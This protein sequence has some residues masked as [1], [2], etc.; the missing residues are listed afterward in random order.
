VDG[1][2]SPWEAAGIVP[3]MIC[4][5]IVAWGRTAP[6]DLMQSMRAGTAVGAFA[7]DG[8]HVYVYLLVA[9]DSPHFD[10]PTGERMWMYDSIELWLE[11]EQIGLGFRQDGRPVL[12]KY[13]FHDRDGKQYAAG[14]AL[15]DGNIWGRVLPSLADHPLSRTLAAATGKSFEGRAGYALMAKIPFEDI[16][17]VGGIAGRAGDKILPMTGQTGEIVRIGVAIDCISYAG[18]EQDY[19]VYWPCGLMFSDPMRNVPFAL[20]E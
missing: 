18:R 11:E 13:R 17:L 19:K 2:W 14:Y 15:A 20:G 10:A 6:A 3:Q 9:D 5:P 16:K 8:Q 1:D 4:L 12:F 7:H